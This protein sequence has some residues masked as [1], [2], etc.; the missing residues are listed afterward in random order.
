MRKVILATAMITLAI[1]ATG[2]ASGAESTKN[3]AEQKT[4][5]ELTTAQRQNMAVAHEKMATCLRSEKLFDECHKEMMKTCKDM[6]GK[7][8]CPMMGEMHGMKGKGMKHHSMMDDK[9]S[10]K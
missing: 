1:G 9:T 6:M 10:E 3:P 5:M 7:E 2:F 8:G 4:A